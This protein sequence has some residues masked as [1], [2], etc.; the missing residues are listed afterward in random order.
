[1]IEL[2]NL[3]EPQTWSIEDWEPW[4]AVE[5]KFVE[6]N[7]MLHHEKLTNYFRVSVENVLKD[8]NNPEMPQSIKKAKCT[9]N[10]IGVSSAQAER[11]FSVMSS[12]ITKIE[13]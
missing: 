12:I 5:D 3:I 11:G 10:T 9:A 8:C 1:M 6:L 2:F 4:K 13:I 7:R